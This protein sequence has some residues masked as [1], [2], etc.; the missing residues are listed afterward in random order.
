ML[1]RSEAFVGD[2]KGTTDSADDVGVRFSGGTLVGFIAPNKTYAFDAGGTAALV[3]VDGLTLSGTL[4][5]Q[6]NTTVSNVN[7]S[8]TVAGVQRTLDVAAN[9]S[10]VGGS[11]T[12]ITPI[13]SL[14]ADFAVETVTSVDGRE[15][16][17][18]ANNVEAFAGDD[19]GTT[20]SADDVGVQIG[21]AHV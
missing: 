15:T 20:D 3:G 1:F 18:A 8:I 17:F 7:R 6:K 4:S 2:D 21:R 10:R 5:A 16:L 9:T 11:V 14:S 13:A 12:L 19:K